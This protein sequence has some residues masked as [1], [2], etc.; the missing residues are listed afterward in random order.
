M[1]VTNQDGSGGANSGNAGG[2]GSS[3]EGGNPDNKP[4]AYETYQR[5]LDEAKA[6]K[7]KAKEL[8]DQLAAIA[9]EKAEKERLAAEKAGDTAKLLE[10]ERKKREELEGKLSDFTSKETRRT[11]LAAALS[12]LNGAVDPK[13]Y[14]LIDF[15]SIVLDETGR[16]NDLS[17][18]K[19]VEKF[20]S[21][22]PE[23]LKAPNGSKLPSKAPGGGNPPS[24]I[25]HAEWLKLPLVDKKKYKSGDII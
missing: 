7:A 16:P 19:V 4:V 11:K 6:A 17:V 13:F 15:D 20:K 10:L 21:E 9:N 1:T 2:A 25:A 23:V 18:Q 5:T 3:N 14:E 12:G 24:K 8:E 22:Y